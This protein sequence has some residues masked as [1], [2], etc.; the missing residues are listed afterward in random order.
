LN[1]FNIFAFLIK[2]ADN[3]FVLKLVN[4][5]IAR[6]KNMAVSQKLICKTSK[7]IDTI[8]EKGLS[9]VASSSSEA[10]LHMPS[11]AH[12]LQYTLTQNEESTGAYEFSY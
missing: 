2:F 6:Q 10:S 8:Y 11:S 4:E 9:P 5:E 7:G 12:S 3:A 1:N